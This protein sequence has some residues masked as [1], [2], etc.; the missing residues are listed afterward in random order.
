MFDIT[1]TEE[2]LKF[3]ADMVD[4]FNFGQRGY[5]DGNRNEQLTGILG[6]T[7]FADL[8]ND[9][10]P[11]GETGFDGGKDFEINSRRVDIKTMTRTVPMRQYF[12]HNFVGYQKPYQVDYYVF[13]SF[14]KKTR[15]LTICGYVGKDEFFQLADFFPKGSLRKRSDGT[16]LRTFAP[17]YEIKQE[18]LHSPDTIDSLIDRIH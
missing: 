15:I 5:G 1:V 12:V 4:R 18:Y 17:L 13:A 16:F 3:A 11:N 10:R 14:N 6:Q 8:I 7:V 9:D 2:Q